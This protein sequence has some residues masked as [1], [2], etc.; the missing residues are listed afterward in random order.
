GIC[1]GAAEGEAVAFD[2]A[3]GAAAAEAAATLKIDPRGVILVA[4]GK[5]EGMP[6]ARLRDSPALAGPAAVSESATCLMLYTSGTTGRPKRRAAQPSQR[7]DG[8]DCPHC[9]EPISAGRFRSWRDAVLPH[10]GRAHN[11][12]HGAA[13]WQTGVCA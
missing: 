2:G 3:W 4:D 12:Q 11:A 13:Q 9:P 10:D 1:A 7:A 8:G 6:F 5:G